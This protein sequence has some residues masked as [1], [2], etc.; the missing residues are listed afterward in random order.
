MMSNQYRWLAFWCAIFTLV[1][2][3]FCWLLPVFATMQEGLVDNGKGTWTGYRLPKWLSWFQ[4]PDNDLNGDNTFL[5]IN[6]N[7]YWARVK[8]L[9]RNPLYGYCVRYI[10]GNSPVTVEGNNDIADGVHGVAGIRNVYAAGLFQKTAITDNGDGTCTIS[11]YGW[12][13][14]ALADPNVNPKPNPYQA[15]FAFTPWRKSNFTPL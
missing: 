9:W 7:G 5:L 8:W 2:Y 11:N 4:T 14:H 10:D 13:I 12:N 15:T 1:A 6:G 3:L